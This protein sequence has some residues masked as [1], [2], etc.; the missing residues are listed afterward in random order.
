MTEYDRGG[1][2]SEWLHLEDSTPAKR[3]LTFRLFKPLTG[4][5]ASGILQGS[6]LMGTSEGSGR[7]RSSMGALGAAPPNL[8]T[9]KKLRQYDMTSPISYNHQH[10]SI[11]LYCIKQ[12]HISL[13]SIGNTRATK[14]YRAPNDNISHD[15]CAFPRRH[16]L[17]S[18]SL[19]RPPCR[20]CRKP[21]ILNN[22]A[23]T[24]PPDRNIFIRSQDLR[25]HV[26]A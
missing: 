9:P 8:P 12:N 14:K 15:R 21:L 17:H 7:Q 2:I 13:M 22:N 26:Q 10:F 20:S 11:N 24:C 4:S 3:I 18:L 6:S 1:D 16:L 5:E 19:R 25:K 23:N